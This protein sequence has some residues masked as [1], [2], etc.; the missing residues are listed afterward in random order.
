MG[1]EIGEPTGAHGCQAR[2][3][4]LCLAPGE[5]WDCPQA[6]ERCGEQVQGEG[7]RG[8]RLHWRGE[9]RGGCPAG[10]S[11]L[12]AVFTAGIASSPG[13]RGHRGPPRESC[14]WHRGP[15]E[16]SCGLTLCFPAGSECV[17]SCLDHNSESIILPVNVTV[18]DIP[19][20]LNPT[21]VEVSDGAVPRAP[22]DTHCALVLHWPSCIR[23][24]VDV[25]HLFC[26]VGAARV[27]RSPL[28]G[29]AG[30]LSFT[31]RAS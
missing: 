7:G 19:H 2:G 9:R 20:W 26:G 31:V 8:C 17:T 16:L 28:P 6:A 23:S 18:R 15:G 30:D 4:T 27:A 21:R 10:S 25:W 24:V 13:D 14:P 5:P 1:D 22:F 12:S 11:R 29:C 3:I